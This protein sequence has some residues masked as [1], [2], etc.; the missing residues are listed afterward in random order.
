MND[1]ISR[2][3]AARE[4]A[5][6]AGDAAERARRRLVGGHAATPV[7]VAEAE[8]RRLLAEERAHALHASLQEAF[9]RSASAHDAAADIDDAAGKTS[10]AAE[11]RRE[12][13]A[14]RQRAAELSD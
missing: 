13:R 8:E 10:D 5:K 9:E 12:A 1:P 3:A 7:T 4:R 2:A 14:D 11:H 6:Q